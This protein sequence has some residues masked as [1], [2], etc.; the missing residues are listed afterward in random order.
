VDIA[1]YDEHSR[2]ALRCVRDCLLRGTG[3]ARALSSKQ[4]LR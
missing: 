3:Q 4:N 2:D 1:Q